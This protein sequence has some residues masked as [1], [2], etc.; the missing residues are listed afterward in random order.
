VD[1]EVKSIGKV[2]IMSE[3]TEITSEIISNQFV[4]LNDG[5]CSLGQSESYYTNLNSYL[6]QDFLSVLYAIKDAAFFPQIQEQF[7]KSKS[8]I[9]SLTRSD[10]V[11][12][13]LRVI[14]HKISG[15]DLSSLYNFEY[16]FKPSFSENSVGI[17][18]D[19]NNN[20]ELPNRIYAIIGKNGTGKTQLI[21]SLPIKIS[22]K[23]DMFFTPRTPIFSKVIAVSY[24]VFDHFTIPKKSASFNYI[25]CGLRDEND[26]QL[27]E[28]GL[29]LR[30]HN[31]WKKIKKIERTTKWRKIL[32]N[33][34]DLDIIEEFIIIDEKGSRENKYTVS[35][36][37][38]HKIKDKLSSGQSIILYIISEITA[39]IRFDSLL[40]YDEP[41][42]HLHPNAITQLVNT[43]YELVNEFESYCIIA[44]HSPLV[45]R[46]PLK[47]CFFCWHAHRLMLPV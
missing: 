45:I 38:F 35:I 28:K 44:T 20:S 17:E 6:G 15:Y 4:A 18:F 36:E 24:S 21:T 19:F 10:S 5:F 33:F 46:A 26:N 27:S 37:G 29:I 25:Y 3:D 47:T 39:N 12:R 43:I 11:E 22:T 13:L 23:D 14:K 1:G 34:I 41:E 40:L 7:E 31:T 2:K 9:N 16:E 30:F 8:Y 32:L 42:T